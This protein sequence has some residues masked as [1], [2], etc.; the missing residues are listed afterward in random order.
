LTSTQVINNDSSVFPWRSTPV[1]P[2]FLESATAGASGKIRSL[3]TAQ[4]ERHSMW[5]A[6]CD[7][8]IKIYFI[9]RRIRPRL[10]V[11]ILC[12]SVLWQTLAGKKR[13]AYHF[14]YKSVRTFADNFSGML[15][16]CYYF[17]N[18]IHPPGGYLLHP[19]SRSFQI[20]YGPNSVSQAQLHRESSVSPWTPQRHDKDCT[21]M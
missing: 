20:K 15:C 17:C 10:A 14:L 4:A 6:T 12:R 13:V 7:F 2:I 8:A 1:L 16:L 19:I 18:S 5:L 9:L 21:S 11:Q 3:V